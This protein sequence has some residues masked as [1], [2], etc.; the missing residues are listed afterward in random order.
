[1]HAVSLVRDADRHDRQIRAFGRHGQH[2][3]RATTAAVVGAGGIGS[4]IAQGL[5]H[6]GIG[7]LI[8]VDPD[9][10]EA[11]NLNRLAGATP[12]DARDGTPKAE[13]AAR[14]VRRIPVRAMTETILDTDVWLSL[15]CA[16]LIFGAVDSLTAPI[17]QSLAATG[18]VRVA[19]CVYRVAAVGVGGAEPFPDLAAAARPAERWTLRIATPVAFFTAR[20][21]GVRRVRPFPES[22]WVFADLYRKWNAF[23]PEAALDESTG[24]AIRQNLEV[25]DYRLTMAEHLLKA[26]VP[27]ARGSIGTITYRVADTRRSTPEARAG[28]DALVRF[29]A[30]SGI[31]DRTTIGMGHVLPQAR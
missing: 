8:V 31:G 20:E 12:D 15:R 21:E 10:V 16:D 11:T 3:L 28:L 22:E 1:M 23:A 29:S 27:P 7:R 6:L 9:V 13:A 24:Q 14:T 18:N 25:A 26:G 2:R 17:L 30:Y 19:R 5:A 4:L